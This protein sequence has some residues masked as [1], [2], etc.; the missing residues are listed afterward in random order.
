MPSLKDGDYRLIGAIQGSKPE[1]WY[2]Q[3][4]D[5]HQTTNPDGSFRLSCDCPAWTQDARNKA[6]RELEAAG[7]SSAG[8]RV[9]RG[10]K[11]T[12]LTA[13]MLVNQPLERRRPVPGAPLQKITVVAMQPLLQGFDTPDTQWR[14]E[15]CEATLDGTPYRFDLLEVITPDGPQ[16]SAFVALN[17][18]HAPHLQDVSAAVASWAGWAVAAEIARLSGFGQV[19][20]PPDNFYRHR[21]GGNGG[22]RRRTTLA[23]AAPPPTRIGVRDLL[24]I[25]EQTDLGDGLRPQQ[26]A[27]A[28]LRMF[29]GPMYG[30]LQRQGFLDVSSRRYGGRVYRLRLDPER[31][32]DRRVRVFEDGRY[33]RDLCIVRM[34]RMTPVQDGFLTV[35]MGLLSDEQHVLRVVGSH[36]IF[37]PYSDG[38]ERETTP[39]IWTPRAA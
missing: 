14:I 37:N 38:H 24:A 19:G 6:A 5:A 28:T 36:N 16:A 39:A 2:R 10:C 15:E 3:C 30:Q 35:F 23:D 29:L 1:N 8:V 20:A 31:R 18:R 11:H 32:A 13:R 21:A 7:R 22:G 9:P 27:E 17:Q 25:G 33:V 12:D 4:L 34:D 26:R